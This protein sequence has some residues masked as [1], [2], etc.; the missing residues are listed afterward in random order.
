MSVVT[1]DHLPPV[2]V[3]VGM[4]RRA[5]Q[6]SVVQHRDSTISPM[7]EVMAL[8]AGGRHAAFDAALVAF[9]QRFA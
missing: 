7:H 2:M 9:V 5:Q 6:T 4:T 8:A 3:D 1:H